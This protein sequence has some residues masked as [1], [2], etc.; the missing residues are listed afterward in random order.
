MATLNER[1]SLS[2]QILKE[3][4]DKHSKLIFTGE[5][6]IGRTHLRRLLDNGYLERIIKGWYMPSF[7]GREG[8]TSIWYACFWDF[9]VEYC[10]NRFGQEWSLTPEESLAIHSG[11][12]MIPNQIV[13]RSPKASNNVITL[14]HGNSMLDITASLPQHSFTEPRFGIKLYPIPEALAM[15]SPGYFQSEKINARTCLATIESASDILRVVTENGNSLRAGRIAGAM[16]NIGRGDI[17]DEI[18]TTMSRLGYDVREDDPFE[19]K[20]II[21]FSESPYSA[22]IRLTWMDMRNQILDEALDFSA[23]KKVDTDDIIMKMDERYVNDAYNSLSIEGYRVTEELIKKVRDGNWNPDDDKDDAERKNALA[24]RGY[25]QA[26]KR[27]RESVSAILSGEN[28]GEVFDKEHDNWHFELFEP[29]VQAG[30]ISISE[31]IGYRNSQVYIRGSKHTPLNPEAVRPAMK[32]LCELMK[33]EDNSFIRSILGHFFFVYIHPYMDG[34]G[35]TARFVLNSMLCSSNFPWTI[36]PLDKRESYM[37]VLEAASVGNDIRPFAHFI[38]N[39][40]IND[41]IQ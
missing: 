28:P 31:L 12:Y 32:T 38:Y 15:A 36:V 26:F 18:L 3:F 23:V 14:K 17:S 35:R 40:M 2:L 22:R 9:I 33:T 24:A 8:D 19:D 7:P 34:N 41:V 13:I 1:L 20:I 29:C 16:R 30:I 37:Q 10:N 5:G 11:N 4:Q 39:L 21:P 25:Y 6:T 27:V